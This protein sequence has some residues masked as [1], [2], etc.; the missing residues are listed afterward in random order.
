MGKLKWHL[1][2]IYFKNNRDWWLTLGAFGYFSGAIGETGGI[3]GFA[4]E[5]ALEQW[6]FTSFN[7]D[8]IE[9][10]D[11]KTVII[12][13]RHHVTYVFDKI[14]LLV[15]TDIPEMDRGRPAGM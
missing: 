6:G 8:L 13:I 12:H 2:L 7:A 1:N 10:D 11:S 9:V 4:A 15:L 5:N 3:V 14:S